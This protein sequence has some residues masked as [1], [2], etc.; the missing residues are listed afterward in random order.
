[1]QPRKNSQQQ[2]PTSR[3]DRQSH[4]PHQRNPG[5][6][7]STS[8]RT[9]S[10]I[11]PISSLNTAPAIR[12]RAFRHPWN[13]RP[14]RRTQCRPPP[15]DERLRNQNT[16]AFQRRDDRGEPSL[17]LLQRSRWAI[18]S[19]GRSLGPL[20]LSTTAARGSRANRVAQAQGT[21]NDS[22]AVPRSQSSSVN[23][24]HASCPRSANRA[25]SL[26][27][28][29]SLRSQRAAVAIGSGTKLS[30]SAASC[31]SRMGLMGPTI[32]VAAGFASGHR[33]GPAGARWATEHSADGYL[34]QLR[35]AQSL[36]ASWRLNGAGRRNGDH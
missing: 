31:Q 13:L 11:W 20:S 26:S 1:M 27:R 4:Q 2:K 5:Q 19:R 6:R 21:R 10:C 35:P 3:P 23:V 24:A 8:G 17:L 9:G 16:P 28:S 30:R 22:V 36:D 14:A 25:S 34:H 29:Q 18:A 12:I 15:T 32:V 33:A 7:R